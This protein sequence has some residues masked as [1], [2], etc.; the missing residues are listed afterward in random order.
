MIAGT[1]ET[2][3]MSSEVI[4]QKMQEV[5]V[6]EKEQEEEEEEEQIVNPWDVKTTSEKG[7]DYEKLISKQLK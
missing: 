5:K 3:A 6:E 4:E 2:I 7:I 1:E